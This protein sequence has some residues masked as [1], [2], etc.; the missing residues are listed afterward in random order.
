MKT[1][2]NRL[3]TALRKSLL[4]HAKNPRNKR[5]AKTISVLGGVENLTQFVRF[6]RAGPFTIL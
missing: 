3:A 6:C 4:A 2:A 5:L 1:D